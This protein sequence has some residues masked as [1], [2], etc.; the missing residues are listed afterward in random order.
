MR[1]SDWS[2]DVCSSDL[3]NTGVATANNCHTLALEQRTIAVRAV[4][5]TVVAVFAL[6][7]HVDFAP[8]RAGCQNDSLAFHDTA[9]GQTDF[10]QALARH[11]RLGLLQVHDVNVVILDVLLQRCRELGPFSFF[12]RNEVFDGHG[13][14]HLPA[15]TFSH[16]TCAYALASGINGCRRAGGTAP[17]KDRTSVV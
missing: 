16:D 4:G 5:H 15:K 12:H 2:S 10:G 9:I 1:I 6:A 17:D 11:Q 8:A 7:G 13:V 14:E 3:F